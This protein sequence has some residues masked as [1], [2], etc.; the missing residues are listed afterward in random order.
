MFVTLHTLVYA[1]SRS[2][3]EELG[4]IGHQVTVLYGKEF[5]KQS[6]TDEKCI[7]EVVR[8]NI[9]L[10]MPEEGWKAQ[11]LIEIAKEENIKYEPTPK[12]KNAYMKYMEAKQGPMLDTKKGGYM[13]DY[14]HPVLIPNPMPQPILP[15]G[16]YNRNFM[17][18]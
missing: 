11:R 12:L 7:N 14:S 4:K 6:E 3:I 8:E 9:N 13:V 2:G 15:S 10:I 5:A 16:L 1:S 18:I 17:E